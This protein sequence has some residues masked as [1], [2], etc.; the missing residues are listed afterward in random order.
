MTI[1]IVIDPPGPRGR[2]GGHYLSVCCPSV[3]PSASP[4]EK[5]K[6]AAKV[7]EAQ[8]VTKFENTC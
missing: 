5:Q 7:Y 4:F 2:I 1:A 8:W 3:L 6:H